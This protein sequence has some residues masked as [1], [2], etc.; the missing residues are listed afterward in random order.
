[1]PL[2]ALARDSHETDEALGALPAGFKGVSSESG[3]AAGAGVALM[4]AEASPPND[5]GGV[6][7]GL[8]SHKRGSI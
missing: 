6:G 2:R 3:T 7:G 1:M 8:G 5:R 4:M